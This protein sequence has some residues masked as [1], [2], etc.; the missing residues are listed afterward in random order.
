MFIFNSPLCNVHSVYLLKHVQS[1]TVFVNEFPIYHE[2][3]KFARR[4]HPSNFLSNEVGRIPFV[5]EIIH[6]NFR[7][8]FYTNVMGISCCAPVHLCPDFKDI[9]HCFGPMHLIFHF[10]FSRSIRNDPCEIKPFCIFP[11]HGKD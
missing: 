4:D 11:T 1:F 6:Y 9:R 2:L 7:F 8:H 5:Y 3:G 10:C